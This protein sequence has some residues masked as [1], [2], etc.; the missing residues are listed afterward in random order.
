MLRT[1][2]LL[3]LC[4]TLTALAGQVAFAAKTPIIREKIE[5]LD[6]WVPD[7]QITNLPH[8]LLIGDSITRAY[9]PLVYSD[10][11]GKA[12]VARLATSKCAADPVLIKEVSLLLGQYKF[13]VIQFNNGMHGW[14][15]TEEEYGAGLRKL[16]HVLKKEAPDAKLIWATTTAVRNTRDLNLLDNAKTNRVEARNKIAAR[17][18]SKEDIPTDDLFSLVAKRPEYYKADGVH[19]NA[20]GERAEANQVAAKV[21]T[22]LH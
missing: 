17:I 22:F 10:L 9:Y 4:T 12:V 20:N 18:M 2:G 8:V 13:D 14:G 11:K 19:P 6:I 7:T 1:F 16:V 5:W 21:A 3:I 15:Y